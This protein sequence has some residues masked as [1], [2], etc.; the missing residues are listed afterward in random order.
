MIALTP[1]EKHRQRQQQKV[2]RAAN[3]EETLK[4]YYNFHRSRPEH[5]ARIK[6]WHLEHKDL[7]N[8]QARERC[9]LRRL[10]KPAD[11]QS[12]SSAEIV[13]VVD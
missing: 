7:I 12:D 4:T 3:P 8:W 10:A 6:A 9:R 5:R 13:E 1:A 2:W 11:C